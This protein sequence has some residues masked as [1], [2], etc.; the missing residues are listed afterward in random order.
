MSS[1]DLARLQFA[2]TT[3]IH[4]LFVILTMGLVPLVAVMHTRAA[5]TRDP[6]AERSGS[7]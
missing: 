7:G 4:W 6:P 5:Y 1:V 3:G 2:A